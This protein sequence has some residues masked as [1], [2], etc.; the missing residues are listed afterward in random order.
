MNKAA[1]ESSFYLNCGENGA[2]AGRSSFHVWALPEGK[3][4]SLL[5]DMEVE[6]EH[7][8]SVPTDMNVS[9][10]AT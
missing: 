7:N 5:G 8:R 3:A 10:A 2:S 9:S 1:A 4:L 6:P